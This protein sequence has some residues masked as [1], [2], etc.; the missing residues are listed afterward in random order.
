MI[1]RTEGLW[2]GTYTRHAAESPDGVWRVCE[3]LQRRAARPFYVMH[4]AQ[5]GR[6]TTAPR[7][8]GFGYYKTEAAARL[9]VRR[10]RERGG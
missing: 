5:P 2:A 7:S 10:Y 1:W 3:S 4:A 8:W 6:F 9:A